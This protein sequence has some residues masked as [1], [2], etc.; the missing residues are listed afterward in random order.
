MVLKGEEV[1]GA[2][3]H[4]KAGMAHV[5]AVKC[6]SSQDAAAFGQRSVPVEWSTGYYMRWDMQRQLAVETI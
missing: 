4:D 2:Q 3:T 6:F 1:H 5:G